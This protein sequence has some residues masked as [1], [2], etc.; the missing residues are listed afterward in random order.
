MNST[1]RTSLA[2]IIGVLA[3]RSAEAGVNAE[4]KATRLMADCKRAMGGP[5]VDAPEAFH[6]RGV[7]TRDGRSGAYETYG[8]LRGLRS[9]GSQTFGGETRWAG[10]DGG[11]YW[12]AG[13]DGAV[14]KATDEQTLR[15]ERLGTYLTLSGYLYPDRFP[16]TFRYEGRRRTHGAEFDL[17]RVTPKDADSVQL[18][19]DARSHRL[20]HLEASAGREK[21]GAD[22]SDYRRVAGTWVGYALDVTDNGHK[23]SLRLTDFDY[24]PLNKAQLSPPARSQSPNP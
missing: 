12:R 3:A 9:A 14:A 8:D 18:W 15:G 7:M 1:M 19:L 24:V 2:S 20:A 22:V 6:E 17:V 11:A 10:F 13:P 23:V 5:A 16:A 4:A 21:V